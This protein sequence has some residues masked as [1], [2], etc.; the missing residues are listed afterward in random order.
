M[1]RIQSI[2]SDNP[3]FHRHNL[4]LL[5]EKLTNKESH[6]S[7][8]NFRSFVEQLF[9]IFSDNPPKSWRFVDTTY[10]Y[11]AFRVYNR[12]TGKINDFFRVI[13]GERLVDGRLVISHKYF[14]ERYRNLF[15]IRNDFYGTGDGV[16]IDYSK[17]DYSYS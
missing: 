1:P 17:F 9:S 12:K 11:P 4:K 5:I 2:Q 8:E 3:E 16:K 10:K 15:P 13:P 6:R 14:D 7:V